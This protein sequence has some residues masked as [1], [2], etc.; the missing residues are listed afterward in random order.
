MIRHS[1]IS[2]VVMERCGNL[3]AALSVYEAFVRE[4]GG[5]DISIAID[6]TNRE[7]LPHRDGMPKDWAGY[8]A[9]TLGLCGGETHLL[10]NITDILSGVNI[11]ASQPSFEAMLCVA[12]D[13]DII[14]RNYPATDESLLS[15]DGALEMNFVS[16]AMMVAKTG[17][18]SADDLDHLTSAPEVTCV[19]SWCDA[20]E[21]LA[22]ARLRLSSGVVQ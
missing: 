6:G 2:H 7:A 17:N 9:T 13:I 12:E 1:T 16:Y 19:N 4:L 18:I 11:E 22:T 15:E 5:V 10:H 14:S 8:F 20:I 3:L 21:R